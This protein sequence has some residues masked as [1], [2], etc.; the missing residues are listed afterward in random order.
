[1]FIPQDK[2]ITSNER[3]T[4]SEARDISLKSEETKVMINQAYQK[5]RDAASRGLRSCKIRNNTEHL[6]P[7]DDPNLDIKP[8]G[9]SKTICDELSNSG[10]NISFKIKSYM[11]PYYRTTYTWEMW[12][13]W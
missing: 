9:I 1:M 10:F 3:I 13:G 5:I 4:A 2:P 8:I 6:G 12:A 11:C 7:E